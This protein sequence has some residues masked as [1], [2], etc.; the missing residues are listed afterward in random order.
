MNHTYKR[1]NFV[2]AVPDK[3][4]F[5]ICVVFCCLLNASSLSA[6]RSHPLY[7]SAGIS[8]FSE[9]IST[10]APLVNAQIEFCDPY[11][12]QGDTLFNYSVYLRNRSFTRF[13]ISYEARIN[14]LEPGRDA[15]LSL[16]IPVS[17]SL[18]RYALTG[19]A[20]TLVFPVLTE[21]NFG[22]GSQKSS[23]RKWGF[24][25]GAGGQLVVAGLWTYEPVA[26]VA[27][28]SIM[29]MQALVRAGVRMR[30]DFGVLWFLDMHVGKSQVILT[31]NYA[32]GGTPQNPQF[33][34]NTPKT[35]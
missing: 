32:L 29:W 24:H 12:A 21:L 15:A 17:L 35:G 16:A 3:I 25:A 9:W 22:A 4:R 26:P 14:L 34:Q 2:N 1:A 8:F 20:G 6:Q 10:T 19:R 31:D 23:N 33:P 7:H 28:G 27:E 11:N 30:T 5:S 13:A 18:N